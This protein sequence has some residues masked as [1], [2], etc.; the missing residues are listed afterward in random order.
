MSNDLFE[1]LSWLM[2]GLTGF[3]PQD[4]PET[5]LMNTQTEWNDLQAKETALYAKNGKQLMEEEPN[6]AEIVG[7]SFETV[8]DLRESRCM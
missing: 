1:N 4:S 8:P 5:K 7:R 2:R 6:F 3:M